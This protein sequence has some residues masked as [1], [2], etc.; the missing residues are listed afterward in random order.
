M[1]YVIRHGQNQSVENIQ[2]FFKRV[3]ECLDD[4]TM[5]YNKEDIFYC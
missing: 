3:Y 4:I 2:E 5:T 1:I